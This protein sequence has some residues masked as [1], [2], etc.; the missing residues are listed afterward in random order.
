[1]DLES[2]PW[3]VAEG[4]HEGAPL[5]IR[6]RQFPREFE[7]GLLPSRLNVFWLMGDSEPWG[8]PTLL[9]SGR[10][11]AFEERLV[12]AVEHDGHSVLSVVLTCKGQREFVFHTADV[13]GF[14]ERLSAMPQEAERY[15][16]ELYST[17]DSAWEYDASVTPPA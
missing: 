2:L 16:I 17:D 4:E 12:A 1:M 6:F 9:E 13:P 8:F 7:Q 10:L 3:A 14:L 15:P 5:L 11:D